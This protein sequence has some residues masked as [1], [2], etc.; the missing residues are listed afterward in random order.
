MFALR[1]FYPM[2][3]IVWAT[4]IAD[5]LCCAAAI[6]LFVIFINRHGKNKGIHKETAA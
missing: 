1:I 3:G 6:V 5:I 4:P 2:Y